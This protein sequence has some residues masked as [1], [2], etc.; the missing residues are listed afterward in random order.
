MTARVRLTSLSHG[1]GCACKLGADELAEVL[2][3]VPQISDPRVLV[4]AAT[5][6]DAA[7]FQFSEDRALV[8]TLDFFAPI[9][10]DPYAF[11]AIAAANALSDIYSMGGTPLL[12]LNILAWPRK[13]EILE[14]LGEVLR[15][16]VETVNAAGALLVG[17][18]SIDDPE[19]KYGMVALGEVR[20]E[21]L[22]TNAGAKAGDRLVLTKAIGTGVL[23]TALKQDLLSEA[24]IEPAVRSMKML[25]ALAAAAMRAVGKAAH[26][27]T[28]VTG[29]GLLGHLGNMVQASK[30]GARVQAGAVPLLP[31]ARE[32]TA[33]GGVPGGTERNRRSTE[34]ATAWAGAVAEADRILLNDAQTSGGLLIA[35]DSSRTDEL[36]R[37]LR[38]IGEPV[39]AAV[40]G[41]ITAGPVGTIEVTA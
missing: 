40:I 31:H 5:R 22:I 9:V 41:E 14:L 10:D 12:A 26:A 17:G 4:D 39:T 2:K 29:F 24:D 23:S 19:P 1:A 28:D 37:A 27:A 13:P 11:G 15:G 34:A 38:K 7:V 8:A 36:V 32:M 3:H 25:N 16:G 18:H 35:V 30:V 33:R 6:D 20:P 21:N